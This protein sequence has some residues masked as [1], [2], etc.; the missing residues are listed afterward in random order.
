[1][2]KYLSFFC[3]ML[4]ANYTYAAN[5]PCSGGK[6]GIAYCDG[7]QF[8][9]NDGSYSASKKICNASFYGTGTKKKQSNNVVST[10]KNATKATANTPTK[11]VNIIET[12]SYGKVLTRDD[13]SLESIVERL[14]NHLTKVNF[15]DTELVRLPYNLDKKEN[16]YDFDFN[17]S[18]FRNS[19][20]HA[21]II[22]N[23]VSFL[24]FSVKDVSDKDNYVNSVLVSKALLKTFLIGISDSDLKN[25]INKFIAHKQKSTYH[26]NNITISYEF[27]ATDDDYFSEE[28]SFDTSNIA[29]K[30]LYFSSFNHEYY[31][32]SEIN[33]LQNEL[34]ARLDKVAKNESDIESYKRELKQ[35][36][37]EVNS[38]DTAQTAVAILTLGISEVVGY[39][40]SDISKGNKE[41]SELNEAIDIRTR[42]IK[43]HQDKINNL[44]EILDSAKLIQ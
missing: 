43:I 42:E 21:D 12:N 28:I 27:H 25:I 3:T 14:N 26:I 36:K 39:K 7:E 24:K 35:T 11:E 34:N 20:F 22:K 8:V 13:L 6:G 29:K 1:M 44:R 10:S 5:T 15:T 18:V 19:N 37:N 33:K 41:I 23:K 32:Q 4:V 17:S 31:D 2:K 9:C 30:G 38:D 16:Y 40:Q